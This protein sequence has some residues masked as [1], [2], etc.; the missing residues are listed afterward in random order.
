MLLTI[1]YTGN[2]TQDL[3]YLLQKNP[4]RPQQ[5]EVSYGKAY[6]FYPKVSD[7]ETTAALLLDIRD[8]GQLFRLRDPIVRPLYS[9][10]RKDSTDGE[11]AHTLE[12]YFRNGRNARLTAEK[13]FIH[14]NTLN[15]RLKKIE[16]LCGIDLSDPACCR[17][18]EFAIF[19]EKCLLYG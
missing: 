2:E 1:T 16:K 3:G 17:Q 18:V 11:L 15:L 13:M 9:V 5:F 8:R 14:R 7:E 19:V 10:G 6:V 4:A 12:M